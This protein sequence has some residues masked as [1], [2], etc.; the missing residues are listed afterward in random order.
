[1]P[2]FF[3]SGY[4]K[5]IFDFVI[6]TKPGQIL[7]AASLIGGGAAVISNLNK[8]SEDQPNNNTPGISRVTP[9]LKHPIGLSSKSSELIEQIKREELDNFKYKID[10]PE[11]L[12]DPLSRQEKKDR[13]IKYPNGVKV[14]KGLCGGSFYIFTPEDQKHKDIQ[15][16]RKKLS[17][18]PE[19][20][21]VKN[22]EFDVKQRGFNFGKYA[23]KAGSSFLIPSSQQERTIGDKELLVH[24]NVALDEM[25]EHPKYGSTV[26][27]MIEICG[28]ERLMSLALATA[29][30]RVWAISNRI[31]SA[32]S[33]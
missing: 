11:R 15:V 31:L 17:E 23:I 10:D 19:Y 24:I 14:L 2:G 18:I 4:N 27:R 25:L 16:I 12:R 20:S 29:K 5:A 32:I 21:Y 6:K 1:L 28:R 33:F 9:N 7:L 22:D 8:K 3:R 26:A 30:K 13:T